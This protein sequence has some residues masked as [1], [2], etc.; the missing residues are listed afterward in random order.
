MLMLVRQ[1]KRR[2]PEIPEKNKVNTG[3]Q[4][5]VIL[6]FSIFGATGIVLFSIA[7]TMLNIKNK[8]RI[9]KSE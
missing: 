9:P 6:W 7:L 5:N 1:N 8:Y 2:L 4:T 3:D